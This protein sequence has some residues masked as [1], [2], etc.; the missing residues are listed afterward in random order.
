MSNLAFAAGERQRECP[1]AELVERRG[2]DVDD[3]AAPG[4]EAAVGHDFS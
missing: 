4:V 1:E 2:V 3:L